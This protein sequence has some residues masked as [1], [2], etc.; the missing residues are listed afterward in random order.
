MSDAGDA[1]GKEKKETLVEKAHPLAEVMFE[2]K[3]STL[4]DDNTGKERNVTILSWRAKTLHD[5]SNEFL[6]YPEK[7]QH[8]NNDN[9]SGKSGK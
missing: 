5:S 4:P 9:G 7:E 6:L 8:K 1:R 2:I 3:G